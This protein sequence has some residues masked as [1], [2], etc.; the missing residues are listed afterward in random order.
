MN[1]VTTTPT[2]APPTHWPLER[3]LMAMAGTMS[4]LSALLAAIV[5]PWFLLLTAFVGVNQWLYVTLRGCPASIVL[6]RFGVAAQ[7]KW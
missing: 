4:L 5:S 3:I 7:C 6:K 2:Q 1:T